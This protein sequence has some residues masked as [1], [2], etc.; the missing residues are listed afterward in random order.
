MTLAVCWSEQFAIHDSGRAGLYLPVGGLIEDDVHVDSTAR[1]TQNAESAPD[2]RA[3][4]RR[5]RS[6]SPGR[7]ASRK[8][9][10]STRRSTS[11][12]CRRCQ[13]PAGGTRAEATRPMDEHSYDL[14]L[15]SAGSA[16]TAL[17]AVVS[18]GHPPMRCCAGPGTTPGVIPATASASSTTAPSS[19]E[20]LWTSSASS[21][22]RSWT[23]TRIT[24]TAPRRSSTTIRAFSRFRSTRTGASRSRRA[25]SRAWAK[26]TRRERT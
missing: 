2:E 20:R 5:R 13:R 18:G 25:A 24:A 9:C 26:G 12:G 14:A 3:L 22:S 15:L 7:P 4:T 8:S 1:I 21:G 16:L 19:L 10:A 17:E 11:S 6:S 23:S